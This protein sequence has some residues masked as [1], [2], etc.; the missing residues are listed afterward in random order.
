[1]AL[2]GC[3]CQ[4]AGCRDVQA[5]PPID[6][7]VAS[8]TMAGCEWQLIYWP[9][10]PGRGDFVRLMFEEAGVAYDDVCR[11]EDSHLAVLAFYQPPEPGVVAPVFAPPTIRKGEFVLSQTAAI[12]QYLGRL[13][14]LYP[15]G[16]AEEE[17]RAMQLT[18]TVMDYVSEGIDAFHP[19][20][21]TGTYDSQ[22]DEAEKFIEAFKK[23]RLPK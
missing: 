22:K 11:I 9:T 8:N 20:K 16:G 1:M 12:L 21:K 5:A 7:G 18:L 19:I 4:L 13:F 14:G 23:D 6:K 2:W 15:S 3:P 17:A 10:F